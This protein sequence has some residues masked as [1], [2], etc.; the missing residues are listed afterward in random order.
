[1]EVSNFA[2]SER[3][4]TLTWKVS[5]LPTVLEG[6]SFFTL[7]FRLVHL[8]NE[9]IFEMLQHLTGQETGFSA[10]FY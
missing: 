10:C 8:Q 1:M 2:P 4:M 7:K 9:S 5:A 6:A 3:N